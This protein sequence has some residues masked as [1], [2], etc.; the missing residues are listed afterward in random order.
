MWNRFTL[1]GV[2]GTYKTWNK[3]QLTFV[4]LFQ[5]CSIWIH[6]S[7]KHRSYFKS[8]LAGERWWGMLKC[9]CCDFSFR[10][11]INNNSLTGRCFHLRQNKD[12]Y[13]TEKFCF[14][15]WH[16]SSAVQSCRWR[17][18][19]VASSV[20]AE[21][22][23]PPSSGGTSPAPTWTPMTLTVFIFVKETSK[24]C[25]IFSLLLNALLVFKR[26]S[27]EG[28]PWIYIEATYFVKICSFQLLPFYM[29]VLWVCGFR[30]PA[31]LSKILA[32]K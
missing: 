26:Y 3:T 18:P 22:S 15:I 31:K 27:Q 30:R 6:M 25:F 4:A 14:L 5:G 12:Q 23:T 17:W 32:L 8:Q 2:T 13:R 20:S 29:M 7:E 28:L 10:Q 9:F 19:P 1:S 11:R 24:T 21:A 16:F